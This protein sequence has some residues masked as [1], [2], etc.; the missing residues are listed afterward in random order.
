MLVILAE[1]NGSP[2]LKVREAIRLKKSCEELGIPHPVNINSVEDLIDLL[3]E[4]RDQGCLLFSNFPP[5]SSYPESGKSMNLVDEGNSISRSWEA[6]SYTTSRNLFGVL[7]K[8]Y[9]F[10]AIHFVTGAPEM[11]LTDDMIKSLFPGTSV[12]IQRK[13]EWLKTKSDYQHLYRL[14]VEEKI[15]EAL[16]L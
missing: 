8:R 10:K 9:S 16:Q 14:F 13:R 4:E 1:I 15:Q 11:F 7:N 6:G 3:G 2:E 5:N 12:T